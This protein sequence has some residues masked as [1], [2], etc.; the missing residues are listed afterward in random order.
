[1]LRY[2]NQRKKI[3]TPNI[4]FLLPDYFPQFMTEQENTKL[5]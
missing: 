4:G 5:K 3:K 2:V 1:M